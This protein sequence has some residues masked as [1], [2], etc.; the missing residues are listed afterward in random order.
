[1]KRY[2]IKLAGQQAAAFEALAKEHGYTPD[3]F[4]QL[5]ATE[6]IEPNLVRM[7][8]IAKVAGVTTMTVSNTLNATRGTVSEAKQEIIRAA[9]KRLGWRPNIL[10]KVLRSKGK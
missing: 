9:A 1:M 7:E 8:D 5:V 10:A 2:A 4:L 3:E 6:M